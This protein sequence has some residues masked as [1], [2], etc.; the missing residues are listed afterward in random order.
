MADALKGSAGAYHADGSLEARL[1]G[2]ETLKGFAGASGG[3]LKSARY[4]ILP[5]ALKSARYEILPGALKSA[6]YEILPGA[7]KSTS[8]E[9]L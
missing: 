3:A 9:I 1:A 4:E 7:L 8:E 6:R 5:G 2:Q